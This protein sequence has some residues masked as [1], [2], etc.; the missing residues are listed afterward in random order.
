[1]ITSLIVSQSA[2]LPTEWRHSRASRDPA[3]DAREGNCKVTR[4]MIGSRTVGKDEPFPRLADVRCSRESG[5][6]GSFS[7]NESDRNDGSN[8]ILLVTLPYEDPRMLPWS[9]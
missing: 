3:Y 5:R 7:R 9:T 4:C 6:T 8:N 2:F 1:M